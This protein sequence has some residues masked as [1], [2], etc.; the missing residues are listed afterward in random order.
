MNNFE[1]KSCEVL[2]FINLIIKKIYHLRKMEKKKKKFSINNYASFSSARIS[3]QQ[4]KHTK[5][6]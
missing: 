4:G 5:K 2:F 1:L 3:Q 6:N